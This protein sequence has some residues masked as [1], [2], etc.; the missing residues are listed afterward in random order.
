[1]HPP[2]LL[3][4]KTLKHHRVLSH[5]HLCP[6]KNYLL[7]HPFLLPLVVVVVVVENLLLLLLRL[8]PL[9]QP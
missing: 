3:A 6:D 4:F 1:M 8:L 9:K 5:H 7:V 2:R